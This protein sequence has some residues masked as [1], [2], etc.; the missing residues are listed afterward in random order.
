MVCK[1]DIARVKVLF[2]LSIFFLIFTSFANFVAA[3]ETDVNKKLS[4]YDEEILQSLKSNKIS[5][6]TDLEVIKEVLLEESSEDNPLIQTFNI[7]EKSQD[8]YVDQAKIQVQIFEEI[9]QTELI[10]V[11]INYDEINDIEI[12]PPSELVTQFSKESHYKIP[13]S[14][15]VSTPEHVSVYNFDRFYFNEYENVS[16]DDKINIIDYMTLNNLDE[17][18][19]LQFVEVDQPH[20]Y[21]YPESDDS[22]SIQC[23]ACV[24]YNR[25]STTNTDE[26]V[27]V[28]PVHAI[29]GV[30][31][32]LTISRNSNTSTSFQTRTIF[33]NGSAEVSGSRSISYGSQ[34]TYP[35]R[36]GSSVSDEGRWARTQVRFAN[37]L[38]RHPNGNEYRTKNATSWLG[39]TNWGS[40]TGGNGKSFS[41]VTGS[42]YLPGSSQRFSHSSTRTTSTGVNLTAYGVTAGISHTI[43]NTS[44]ISWL[45]SFKSGHGYNRYKVYNS[46]TINN[47][48]AR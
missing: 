10:N 22:I 27:N 39:G 26:W 33:K 1:F 13:Y 31:T 45:F 17:G 3:S 18:L 14:M 29:K 9:N 16:M 12:T 43:S 48:T 34:T 47:L 35:T 28:V 36:T 6:T 2:L 4:K 41:S 5:V 19:D 25:V 24:G 37:S 11:I 38:W 20:T 23:I 21:L 32:T 7:D 40:T 8:D 44:T 46:P 15:I 30:D 42:E